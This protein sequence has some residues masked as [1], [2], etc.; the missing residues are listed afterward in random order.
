M[1]GIDPSFTL[2]VKDL[3]LQTFAEASGFMLGSYAEPETP[4]IPQIKIFFQK[5]KEKKWSVIL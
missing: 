4:R 2:M 3:I 1:K 5:E